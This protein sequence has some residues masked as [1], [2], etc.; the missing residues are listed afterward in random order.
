MFKIGVI[1]AVFL[2]SDGEPTR[3]P[4]LLEISFPTKGACD[5]LR[6]SEGFGEAL[7]EMTRST[8]KKFNNSKVSVDTLC[9]DV[10]P[11]S[12]PIEREI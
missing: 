4:F 2:T 6:T 11:K 7:A 8:S 5:A 9:V 10:E 1:L 12:V 3:Y